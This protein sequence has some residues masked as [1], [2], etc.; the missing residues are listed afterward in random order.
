MILD[1]PASTVFRCGVCE[2]NRDSGDVQ[3]DLGKKIP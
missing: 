1:R 3:E 2:V